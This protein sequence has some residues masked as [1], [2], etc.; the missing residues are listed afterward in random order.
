M[1]ETCDVVIQMV[2]RS[3]WEF[4]SKDSQFSNR[5]KNKFKDTQLLETDFF[6]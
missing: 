2:D 6:K 1:F 5:L 3:S 4:F